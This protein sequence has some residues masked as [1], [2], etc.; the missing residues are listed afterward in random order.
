LFV[1]ALLV[2]GFMD[3]PPQQRALSQQLPAATGQIGGT[4]TAADDGAPLPDVDATLY[5]ASTLAPVATTTTDSLGGYLFTGLPGGSYL[6]EFEPAPF[7]SSRA[8]LGEYYDNQPS[9]L[10]ATTIIL[11]DAASRT[12][13]SVLERGGQIKGTV[14]REGGNVPLEAVDVYVRRLDGTLAGWATT[15]Q[16]GEYLTSG[17]QAG[18]YRVE[19]AP[20]A[21]VSED[22]IGEFYPD[23][24]TLAAAAP[25]EVSMGV[26]TE[27][28][29][30]G[31]VRG[32]SV[33]GQVV[34]AEN[35]SPLD[36]VSV[37][38]FTEDGQQFTTASVDSQGNYA[39]PG[40][41]DG[42]YHLTFTPFASDTSD[43]RAYLSQ[44]TSEPVQVTAP[45]ATTA[46]AALVRGGQIGGTL[47]A[48]GTGAPLEGVTV[49][50]WRSDQSYVGVTRTDGSGAYIT[51]GLGDGSYLLS[52]DTAFAAGSARD[53]Q[54]EV[55][56]DQATLHTAT[57]VSVTAPALT[58]NINAALEQGATISGAVTAADTSIPS[59]GITIELYQDGSWTQSAVTDEEG[60]YTFRGLASGSYTLRAVPPFNRFANYA[61]VYYDNQ[62]QPD[63]ATPVNVTAP[64]VVNNI[65]MVLQPGGTISGRVT[66]W[67]TG[68]GLGT[69]AANIYDSSGE[70]V[71]SAS[72]DEQGYYQTAG[73]SDGSY[74]VQF[75]PNDP[76][77][78]YQGE[79]YADQPS[80]AQADPVPVA[81]PDDTT[82]IDAVLAPQRV[83]LLPFL[84][85]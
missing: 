53:Y 10:T 23:R 13:D 22:Y 66:A 49:Y 83:L 63:Q 52:F 35:S 58:D 40:L 20:G 50:I 24:L 76:A 19:F 7:R 82:A 21:G 39:I 43:A 78:R 30:A 27:N 18:F 64:Q 75:V 16:N 1:L 2:V 15:S 11:P 36:D 17:L 33:R 45:Q 74:R 37:A 80:L 67:D 5:N 38:I 70:L 57:P 60:S 6:V 72:A 69:V 85:R 54:D 65:T 8:Y 56:N 81:A 28:I 71:R 32:G 41:P 46:N 68:E 62:S 12:A 51:P 59:A 26:I 48:S 14:M 42:A 77:N 47:T 3:L 29:H 9:R 73:L 31:L 34:A 61:P 55:Y 84:Q 4:V 44:T 79:Y 25:V